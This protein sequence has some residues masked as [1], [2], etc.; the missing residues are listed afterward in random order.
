MGWQCNPQEGASFIGKG[1]S[2]YVMLL[3][4]NFIASLTGYC[5]RF[6]RIPVFTILLLFGLFCIFWDWQGQKFNLKRLKVYETYSEY[7]ETLNC[8]VCT[9]ISACTHPCD[10][11]IFNHNVTRHN[12]LISLIFD[13]TF[14]WHKWLFQKLFSRQMPFY[15]K[16]SCLKKVNTA[17]LSFSVLAPKNKVIFL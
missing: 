10:T 4:L 3:Y 7:I 9:V 5:K 12:K 15:C 1:G 6:Y 8:R 16:F 14:S 2:H 11:S 13:K 17:V